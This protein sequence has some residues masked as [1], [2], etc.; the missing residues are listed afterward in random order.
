MLKST[1]TVAD[2]DKKAWIEEAISDTTKAIP[3]AE[4]R[5]R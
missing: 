3:E 2:A 5:E 4:Q 1:S